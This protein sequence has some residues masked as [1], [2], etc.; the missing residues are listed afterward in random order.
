MIGLALILLGMLVV[1]SYADIRVRS[2]TSENEVSGSTWTAHV[3]SIVYSNT[4]NSNQQPIVTIQNLGTGTESNLKLEGTATGSPGLMFWQSATP[5]GT[6]GYDNA[7]GAIEMHNFSSCSNV[8]VRFAGNG[9]VILR[10]CNTGT[11]HILL[12]PRGGIQLTNYET[13]LAPA[14]NSV[15]LKST[16]VSSSAELY[17]EDEA[18]NWTLLSPHNENGEW[19]FFSFNIK[20]GQV[21]YINMSAMITD[22]EALTGFNEHEMLQLKLLKILRVQDESPFYRH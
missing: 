13:N 7:S 14:A 18:G 15:V 19:I 22:L 21:E 16:D 3:S 12:F 2:A 11:E 20:T 5:R 10:S 4:T 6:F 17:V 1:S 8:P 9:N